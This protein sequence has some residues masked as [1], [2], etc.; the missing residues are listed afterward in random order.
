MNIVFIGAGNVATQL[1]IAL[2]NVGE[3]IV[4]I[5]SKTTESAKKLAIHVNADFTND[6]TAINPNADI[7]F[8][9]VTDNVLPH[10]IKN[11]SFCKG[12]HI[13]TAGSIAMEIFEK[14][15][16]NYGVLYPLQTFSKSKDIDF[17]NIPF[18]IET[19]NNEVKEIL[20]KITQKISKKIFFANSEERQRIHLAAVFACNFT[21]HM[22]SIA[23]NLLD[24]IPFEVLMPLITETIN[25]IKEIRP[26]EAQ[27]GPAK[28]N[29]TNIIKKHL[30]LLANNPVWQHLY[31][32]ISEDIINQHQKQS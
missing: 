21:N 5:F 24:D 2:K 20:L 29:D 16:Q 17:Q 13:H 3:N 12:I 15:Q 10:L 9:A 6:I 23:E 7:Y 19:S 18:F 14:H 25:K 4:Q 28:R 11:I 22:F 32:E 27:T 1:A 26:H 8:Y 30:Q 31:Q